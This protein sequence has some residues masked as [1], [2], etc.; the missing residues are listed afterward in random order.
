MLANRPKNL[1]GNL[2]YDSENAFVGGRQIIHSVLI[3]HEVLDRSQVEEQS[4]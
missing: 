4:S 3:V 2:V 1:V